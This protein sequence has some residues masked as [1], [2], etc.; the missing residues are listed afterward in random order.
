MIY[1]ATH[2]NSI[3]W[4][5][6]CLIV[7]SG[8]TDEDSG[9][10]T[11]YGKIAK[12]IG[13]LTTSDID[14]KL[15]D[16]NTSKYGFTPDVKNNCI[17]MGFKNLVNV[18]DDFIKVIIEN[19]P[20]TSPKDFVNRA[21]PKKQAMIS[22]I[23]AGAFDS[24]EDRKFTMAWYLWTTCEPKTN[25]NLTSFPTLLKYNLVP[26]DDEKMERGLRIYEF[27]RYLKAVCREK[28]SDINYRLDVRAIDFLISQGWERLIDGDLM[29]SKQWDKIYQSEMDIFRHW[30]MQNKSDLLFKLNTIL[31]KEEWDKYASGTISHW[32]MEAACIYYHDHELLN[33]NNEKYGLSDFFDLPEEPEA[34]KYWYRGNKTIPLFKLTKIAGTCI[35]RNKTKST[36]TLLTPDGVVEVKFRKE[37]FALFDRQISERGAD[38]KKHIV[39]RSWFKRGNM[40]IVNG[41]RS[42]DNFICKK[43]ASTVGHQLYKINEVKSNG[44]LI[45]QDTRYQGG[46]TE[47]DEEV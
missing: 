47:E 11:N 38:G 17:L 5:T 40:I 35:D 44:D 22:L 43:Y 6:A 29:N 12:A 2:W 15:V 16:I 14:V 36:V 26:L 46:I 37:Y 33:I 27:N 20:Y 21:H 30:M 24:I 4:A 31:F 34:D 7:N 41:M 10:S 8:A 39:E 9:A 28:A 18:G 42:G 25:L 23:K 3:Y 13:E 32:E 1:L 45:L 19:R